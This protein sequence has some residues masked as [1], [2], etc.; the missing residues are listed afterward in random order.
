M[1]IQ[2]SVVWSETPRFLGLYKAE[3]NI[4]YVLKRVGAFH[5][6]RRFGFDA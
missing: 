1:G 6:Y 4:I 3:L 2:L 5:R